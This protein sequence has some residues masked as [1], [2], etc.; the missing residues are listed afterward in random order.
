MASANRGG[1]LRLFVQS[2]KECQQRVPAPVQGPVAEVKARDQRHKR[3][4]AGQE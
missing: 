4:A 1:D 3:G 2:R